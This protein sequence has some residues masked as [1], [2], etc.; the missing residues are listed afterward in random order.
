MREVGCFFGFQGV[1]GQER[2][3][4]EYYRQEDFGKRAAVCPHVPP[5]MQPGTE[6]CSQRAAAQEVPTP[7]L[8][9]TIRYSKSLAFCRLPSAGRQEAIAVCLH[10]QTQSTVSDSLCDTLHRPPAMSQA[11]NTEPCPP[12]YVL[13]PAP[14]MPCG[15]DTLSRRDTHVCVEAGAHPLPA[16][17]DVLSSPLTSCA[18][19]IPAGCTG[20][21]EVSRNRR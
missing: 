14:A 3:R 17:G 21:P 12:R 1:C 15:T 8:P 20:T 18:G 13:A 2:W 19:Q 7:P 9:S 4:G 6:R 10:T 16:W 5:A 11:C